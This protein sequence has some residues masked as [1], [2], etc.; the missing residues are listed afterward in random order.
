MK[1][2]QFLAYSRFDRVVDFRCQK[3]DAIHGI[4]QVLRKEFGEEFSS[5]YVDDQMS[6][7]LKNQRLYLLHK[8]V[9]KPWS[10]PLEMWY[11]LLELMSSKL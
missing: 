1:Q 4:H 9:A 11:N 6:T 10:V 7:I 3:H 8:C 2:V 5:A